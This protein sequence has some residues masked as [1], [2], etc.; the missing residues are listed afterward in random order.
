MKFF[1]EK[2][3]QERHYD[4]YDRIE[5]IEYSTHF[6]VDGVP[7][8]AT[9][10]SLIDSDIYI[11]HEPGHMEAAV[12]YNELNETRTNHV[13][14]IIQKHFEDAVALADLIRNEKLK[15]MEDTQ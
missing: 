7:F 8:S 1:F 13:E 4:S 11:Y 6:T 14:F 5:S 3:K 12:I 9:F 15:R 2:W 10:D